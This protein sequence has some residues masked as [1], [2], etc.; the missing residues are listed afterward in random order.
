MED[1]MEQNQTETEARG[2]DRPEPEGGA[3]A[4]RE[5]EN[6]PPS[7]TRRIARFARRHP[8]LSVLTLAG[9]GVLVAPELAF[10]ALLGAGATMFATRRNGR[11][12]REEVEDV[13]DTS[14]GRTRDVLRRAEA[15]SRE[16]RTR[17]RAVVQA[18]Q[19]KPTHGARHVAVRVHGTPS[20]SPSEE[21]AHPTTH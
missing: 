6:G 17:A 4:V 1:A 13:R 10:G 18:A 2:P 3:G 9:V 11:R 15:L 8:R 12:L 21:E 14:G 5:R 16:V 20:A 19:G 7:R